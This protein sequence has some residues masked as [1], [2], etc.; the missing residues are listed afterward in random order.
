MSRPASVFKQYLAPRQ[1]G[2]EH[3]AAERIEDQ[4]LDPRDHLGRDLLIGEAGDEI[5]DA[6]G[7]RIVGGGSVA[8]DA[9]F[10]SRAMKLSV[11][12][13]A[14]RSLNEAMSSIIAAALPSRAMVAS[15]RCIA[16]MAARWVSLG[17]MTT[18]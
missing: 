11:P 5:G 4:E 2:A 9:Y 14:S 15:T 13:I 6:A 16:R 1:A 7:L 10:L 8:H 17:M 3:G 12:M 18:W